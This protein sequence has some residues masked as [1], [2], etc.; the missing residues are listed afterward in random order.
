MFDRARQFLNDVDPDM[1][2]Y[3]VFPF[4]RALQ[5]FQT[6]TLVLVRPSLWDD[7]FENFLLNAEV[8]FPDG[9]RASLEVLR[10][11]WYGQCWTGQTE[12]D[13]M[14]RIYSG[15][16]TG[17]RLSTTAGKLFDAVCATP[18]EWSSLQYFIGRV[19]YHSQATI[20]SYFNALTFADVTSGGQ[21]HDIAQSLLIKRD[22]FDH[23]REVRILHC[24]THAVRSGKV[25]EFPINPAA[26]IDDVMLDPRL[27]ASM[28]TTIGAALKAAGHVGPIE[29]SDLY[30]MPPL[31]IKSE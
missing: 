15:D 12:S 7:P 16:K 31:T 20:L 17:V 24:D 27:D 26:L 18:N 21:N 1:K 14:W 13:A 2:I 25:V 29:Q 11:A 22:T 10:D 19:G 28:V 23:E 6:K 3:R 9:T 8:A 4:W 30:R 5:L